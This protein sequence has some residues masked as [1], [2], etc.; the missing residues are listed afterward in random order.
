[1]REKA[2]ATFLFLRNYSIS[3]KKRKKNYVAVSTFLEVT[4][5]KKKPF[6]ILYYPIFFLI[7]ARSESKII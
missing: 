3:F 4:Y 2:C 5:I 6:K 1:M 7:C